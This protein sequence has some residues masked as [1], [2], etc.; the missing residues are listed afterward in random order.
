MASLWDCCDLD[1]EEAALIQIIKDTLSKE[2]SNK[3]AAAASE[4]QLERTPKT[5]SFEN[6]LYDSLIGAEANCKDLL[7]ESNEIIVALSSLSSHY[8][9]VSG[10][11][12]TLTKTCEQ[13][14]EQQHFLHQTV[15][16]LDTSLVPF[17]HIEKSAVA[18]GLPVDISA[19]NKVAAKGSG[20][21]LAS[22]VSVSASGAGREGI[23]GAA[24]DPRSA[25]F[26][27][28]LNQLTVGMEF[29]TSHT[30]M[31]DAAKY[32][33]YL[34]LLHHRSC[35]VITK[36]MKE[37]LQSAG[38]LCRDN[39]G[40]TRLVPKNGLGQSGPGSTGGVNRSKSG[41]NLSAAG[42]A[43]G[44]STVSSDVIVLE[45]SYIY[46]KFKGLGYRMRELS[47][48]LAQY[49][50]NI[51]TLVAA[52]CQM[53]ANGPA[54]EKKPEIQRS[55]SFNSGGGGLSRSG[56][57]GNG[58]IVDAVMGQMSNSSGGSG[59]ST[60]MGQGPS[61]LLNTDLFVDIKQYY[62]ELRLELLKPVLHD[63]LY[64]SSV[65]DRGSSGADAAAGLS[66][67][68]SS[69]S[70]CFDVRYIFTT[71][72][73]ISTLELQLF[74]VLFNS[75][76]AG[77]APG[78][79]RSVPSTPSA[80]GAV[81]VIGS[82]AAASGK[83]AEVCQIIELLCRYI[84]EN[85]RPRIIREYSVDELCHIITI[86]QH[87]LISQVHASCGNMNMSI[88]Q[89][90]PESPSLNASPRSNGTE[91]SN[92]AVAGQIKSL[93]LSSIHRIVNETQERLLYN[94]ELEIR[95]NVQLF[96]PT[97][98]VHLNY[99]DSLVSVA[100]SVDGAKAVAGSTDDSSGRGTGDGSG[101]GGTM[102]L[103]VQSW[104]P[105]LR[106]SLSL[107]SKLYGII[108]ASVFEDVSRRIISLCVKSLKI[109]T[110]MIKKQSTI[111]LPPK[112]VH[113][114]AQVQAQV[115]KDR[116][117]KS[118][119][120]NYLSNSSLLNGD[121]FLIRHLLI[122]REQLVAFDVKEWQQKEQVLD[123]SSTSEAITSFIARSWSRTPTDSSA[124]TGAGTDLASRLETT[125][126]SG[127]YMLLSHASCPTLHE[128]TVDIK[129]ELDGMLKNSYN[130]LKQTIVK[131]LLGPLEGFL[132][133]VNAILN[134]APAN[135]HATGDLLLTS[136][137][138]QS[139]RVLLSPD[140]R[141]LLTAQSFLKV[142]R[143]KSLLQGVL[144]N[145]TFYCV[146]IRNTLQV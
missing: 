143:L 136:T 114:Q 97:A 87:D 82:R 57:S 89:L 29:L 56:S 76:N 91:F 16:V 10:R 77:S 100:D 101:G 98:A 139:A 92:S 104:Y 18:L 6:K 73:R 3:S 118:N 88:S 42:A 145:V 44:V 38:Q 64:S 80:G 115:G 126:A 53:A 49:S 133:K 107:L 134:T 4:N 25:E 129:K 35:S 81:A 103:I 74:R 2:I 45:S 60:G 12:N 95:N 96:E 52:H 14:L 84:E 22:A 142:D 146:E 122:L 39:F 140:N 119:S 26:K 66:G 17:D 106:S 65:G 30:D 109:G 93:L 48:L 36:S 41:G 117:S 63:M 123:F 61:S 70:L 71:L 58:W 116:D 99:P 121:L 78:S 132:I 24:L 113:T 13:L 90:A 130:N 50:A 33:K 131:I 21:N 9:E 28:I 138:P 32:F 43:G 128:N 137:D 124:G 51:D 105:T 11:S 127:L 112:H 85:I 34:L 20:G 102:S 8:N 46:S 5:S 67:P 72:L 62:I 31:H 108:D 94:V 110:E 69:S 23:V 19:A 141:K 15:E 144:E 59:G 27:E 111:K 7:E 135:I 83:E 79:P 1:A 75:S 37:L 120:V 86:L 40:S 125:S 68:M 55:S 47:S 54:G